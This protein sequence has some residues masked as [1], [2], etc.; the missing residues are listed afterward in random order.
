MKLLIIFIIFL[1]L[2]K[3]TFCDNIERIAKNIIFY[4]DTDNNGNLSVDE[5]KIFIEK[6]ELSDILAQ[7]LYTQRASKLQK[8]NIQN[9]NDKKPKSILNIISNGKISINANQAYPKENLLKSILR[10]IW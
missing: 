1:N 7:K 5:I 3:I 2:L 4:Y 9:L 10:R 8:R 6:F